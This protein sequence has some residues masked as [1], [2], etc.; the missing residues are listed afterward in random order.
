M[1]PD[2]GCFRMTAEQFLQLHQRKGLLIWSREWSID[3]VMEDYRQ[4]DF[5]GEIH[6]PVQGRIR[7]TR[8]LTWNFRR[9]ELLVN[10]EFTDTGEHSWK[11]LQHTAD[12]IDRIH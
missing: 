1:R 5:S 8:G 7:Q 12:V 10:R 4:A 3:V 9:D 6:D 11:C 2:D